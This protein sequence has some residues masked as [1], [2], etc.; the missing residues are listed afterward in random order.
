MAAWMVE[1]GGGR[2]IMV[3]PNPKLRPKGSRAEARRGEPSGA[4]PSGAKPRQV[5][6]SQNKARE[7]KP[8][9][10]KPSEAKILLASAVRARWSACTFASTSPGRCQDFPP[11]EALFK[12]GSVA[13]KL[14]DD[15]LLRLCAGGDLGELSVF[16]AQVGPKGTYRAEHV[17][18]F[19]RCHL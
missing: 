14:L 8:I 11:L 5:K 15:A 10:K 13:E 6:P 1:V 16:S 2:L 18:D 12:G 3:E 17:L 4:E 9:P 7:A 19:R